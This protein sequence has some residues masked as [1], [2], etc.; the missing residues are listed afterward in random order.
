MRYYQPPQQQLVRIGNTADKELQFTT[1]MMERMYQNMMQSEQMQGEALKNVY[2]IQYLDQDAWDSSM[3]PAIEK[4]KQSVSKGNPYQTLKAVRELQSTA[5]PFQK[6]SEAQIRS[7]TLYDQLRL[8]GKDNVFGVNPAEIG[9]INPETGQLRSPQE[10]DFSHYDRGLIEKRMEE[11]WKERMQE[12]YA[13]RGSVSGET[14][15]LEL[16]DITRGLNSE[17][18]D[19]EFRPF[20]GDVPNDRAL[21]RIKQEF[22]INENYRN[23]WLQR[24]GGDPDEALKM[25]AADMYDTAQRVLGERVNTVHYQGKTQNPRDSEE[26]RETP[27]LEG[28]IT[29]PSMPGNSEGTVKD[30][31]SVWEERFKDLDYIEWGQNI[32]LDTDSPITAMVNAIPPSVREI[33]QIMSSRQDGNLKRSLFELH[34]NIFPDRYKEGTGRMGWLRT[35]NGEIKITN[36]ALIN[37][38]AADL[39]RI[40]NEDVSKA[41]ERKRSKLQEILDSPIYKML[42]TSEDLLTNKLLE[43]ADSE[44]IDEWEQATE[45]EYTTESR[46]QLLADLGIQ[47]P[48]SQR[49][50]FEV[51][52]NYEINQ[53][54][55]H[56]TSYQIPDDDIA[57]SL[58]QTIASVRLSGEGITKAFEIV[59]GKKV[60][61]RDSLQDVVGTAKRVLNLDVVP[62][63]GELTLTVIDAKDNRRHIVIP[64]KALISGV[65]ENLQSIGNMMADI[66]SP[67]K[68]SGTYE[69][70]GTTYGF[71]KVFEDGEIKTKTFIQQLQIKPGIDDYQVQ[72]N[73]TPDLISYAKELDFLQLVESG[74]DDEGN[75]KIQTSGYIPKHADG[76]IMGVSGVTVGIGIDLGQQ[77]EEQLRKDG[78]PDRILNQLKPFLGLKRADADNKLKTTSLN[79]TPDDALELSRKVQ[80]RTIKEIESKYPKFKEISPEGRAV[81]L[82]L[83]YQYGSAGRDRHFKT[84]V[85][86]ILNGNYSNAAAS[87]D[88]RQAYSGRRKQEAQ[89]LRNS[90]G[91]S[92]IRTYTTSD[93]EIAERPYPLANI[94]QNL[95]SYTMAGLGYKAKL[96]QHNL[97]PFNKPENYE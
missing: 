50:A 8:Q 15:S 2:G 66:N 68:I 81:I 60:E 55:A 7:K 1:G 73:Y 24:A 28:R 78:V 23:T 21:E 30:I 70:A 43:L 44:L 92:P 56:N 37:Q 89:L 64:A 84:V 39:H 26:S 14:G 71:R 53:A 27:G 32:G 38:I 75:L 12:R 20:F 52:K 95:L 42:T 61:S 46:E 76:Q 97:D 80:V 5:I 22:E 4:F 45:K 91:D 6:A 9:I 59:D 19:S 67:E 96:K 33:S 54:V 69:I 94:T 58:Q 51:M 74:R 72:G 57:K 10:F 62:S 25:A 87:L 65:S 13:Y 77:S 79:L 47:Q 90:S 88:A 29:F 3:N 93:L 82:S 83:T 48:L 63:S 85:D 16:Y 31:E 34:E 11:E 18:L 40:K 36:A 41:I 49:E 35:D 86:D 17:D